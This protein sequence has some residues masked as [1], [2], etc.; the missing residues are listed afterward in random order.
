[1]ADLLY[2]CGYWQFLISHKYTSLFFLTLPHTRSSWFIKFK[3]HL[4]GT[5]AVLSKGLPHK[6]HI[7]IG[8]STLFY[9]FSCTSVAVSL[10]RIGSA[11]VKV[12]VS[13]MFITLTVMENIHKWGMERKWKFSAP[14]RIWKVSKDYWRMPPK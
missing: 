10:S 6:G 3:W 9:R 4:N 7:R 8:G 13:W 12:H 1:M 5:L 11:A 2:L 14:Y